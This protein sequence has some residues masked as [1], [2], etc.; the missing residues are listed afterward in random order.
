[1]A[2]RRQPN[3][4]T[5]P[6]APLTADSVRFHGYDKPLSICGFVRPLAMGLP[7]AISL[8]LADYIDPARLPSSTCSA[9]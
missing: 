7:E 2:Q 8:Y 9:D 1:M 6:G 3:W 5:F 4:V